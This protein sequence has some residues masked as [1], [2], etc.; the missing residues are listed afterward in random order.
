[1]SKPTPAEFFGQIIRAW[2]GGYQSYREDQGNYVRFPNG[3]LVD[4][5]TNF[6]V[7]PNALAAHRGVLPYTLIADDMKALKIEE[8]EEIGIKHYF[9]EPGFDKL[10]WG[11]ATAS[12]VDF[13]WGSGPATSIIHLQRLC[14]APP[15]GGIG[16][17][18][19]GLY[20]KW[21]ASL[22]WAAATQA[23]HDDRL[24]FID[25]IIARNP[26]DEKF[27]QGWY[28]RDNWLSQANKSWWDSWG[29][30]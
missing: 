18:T 4:I 21:E 29:V 7:T 9:H 3:T 28:N 11:P 22:G 15:D 5:G 25:A 1:M 10:P 20:T 17:I 26:D 14:G 13:G 19:E 30:T 12:S 2:E 16:E 27:R 24:R 6:G 23:I 8:A